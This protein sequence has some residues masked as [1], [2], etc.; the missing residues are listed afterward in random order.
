M[1]TI[2][3]P[4][5]PQGD[6]EKAAWDRQV[7]MVQRLVFTLY[8]FI[9]QEKAVDAM[10][11]EFSPD[12][13]FKLFFAFFTALSRDIGSSRKQAV[14]QRFKP[15]DATPLLTKEDL[16]NITAVNAVGKE[17]CGNLT[18]TAQYPSPYRSYGGHRGR[19]KGG[20]GPGK[21]GGKDKGQNW[22][23]FSFGDNEPAEVT[24]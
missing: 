19:G 6:G 16:K 3:A 2:N 17:L 7:R 8:L 24:K 23:S 20:E 13:L 18:R 15:A 10:E 9:G 12:E 21:T 5:V 1:P 22:Q 11:V 14:D 4:T